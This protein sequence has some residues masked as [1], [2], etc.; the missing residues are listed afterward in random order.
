MRGAAGREAG[1]AFVMLAVNTSSPTSVPKTS[2][3]K[4]GK[5]TTGTSQHSVE[6]FQASKVG[7]VE[8][9]F[10]TKSEVD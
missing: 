9:F 2:T 8:V 1:S 5:K 6:A 7:A 10:N 3:T 4:R